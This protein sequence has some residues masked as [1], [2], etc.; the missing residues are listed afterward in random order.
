MNAASPSPFGRML[1]REIG[2]FLAALAVLLQVG[3]T[4]THL[5]AMATDDGAAMS[6]CRSGMADDNGEPGQSEPVACPL[7]QLPQFGGTLPPAP[8][9]ASTIDFA[10]IAVR[11]E[12]A[13]TFV[14]AS[15]ANAAHHARA[16]PAPTETEIA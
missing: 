6:W 8:A 11:Y 12:N 2:R 1:W 9:I 14:P 13:S 7:C 5:A 15:P 16:P 10:G 3:G 4:A